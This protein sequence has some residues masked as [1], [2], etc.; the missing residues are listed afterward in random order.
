MRVLSN[1]LIFKSVFMCIMFAA[2]IVSLRQYRKTRMDYLSETRMLMGTYV[3]IKAQNPDSA[4]LRSSIAKSFDV[5][6]QVES[7]MSTY[8]A[9]SELSK[10]N[11]ADKPAS[12]A[13]SQRLWDVLVLSDS[14][15][16]Q[17]GEA[18]DASVKP[19]IDVWRSAQ[20]NNILPD[21][22]LIKTKLQ[23]IG[24][25]KIVLDVPTHTITFTA[26]GMQLALGGIAKGYAVDEAAAVLR[27][28]GIEHFLIDAGGDIYCEG[29][30]QNKEYWTV[31][32]RNPLNH[33]DIVAIAE[34]TQKAIVTS[35]NYERFY[36]IQD[37]Q[38]SQIFD[39]ASGQPVDT[40]LSATVLAPS[41]A[42]A[43][44]WATAL[45]V[46]GPVQGVEK[47]DNADGIEAYIIATEHDDTLYHISNGFSRYLL[48]N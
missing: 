24:W 4:L 2:L 48:K 7:L 27:Q 18:F 43:D 26:S 39:P 23:S 11:A 41:A 13:V 34:V 42:V 40:A 3:T 14:L 16:H 28:A 9:E 46:M 25:D 30:P 31:G 36:T 6:S 47:V 17:T 12:F 21:P 37:K 22:D 5:I 32:I 10:L 38:Y 45:M 35:G 33:D 15:Y 44:G 1:R 8:R 20:Q 29:H 19:L